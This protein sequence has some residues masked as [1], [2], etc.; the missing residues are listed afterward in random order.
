[1]S[2]NYLISNW[3]WIWPYWWKWSGSL[4]HWHYRQILRNEITAK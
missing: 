3:V 2:L 1:M 4:E